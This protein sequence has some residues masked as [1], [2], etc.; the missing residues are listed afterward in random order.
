MSIEKITSKIISD[1][2]AQAEITLNEA[3]AQCDAILA[4]AA[5]KAEEIV[6]KAEIEGLAEKENLISRKKSVADI[7]GRKVILAEKQNLITECF[8]QALEK[9]VAMDEKQYVDFLAGLVKKSGV[10]E[11]ELIL[12]AADKERIGEALA[13]AVQAAM[14]DS[15]IVLSEE[16]RNVKGGFLLKTGAVYYN[17]TIEALVEEAREELTGEVALQLFQ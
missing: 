13:V 10:M 12:N 14:P 15:R 7:D 11:G 17:S 16:T 2:Q 3:K 4:E 6:K 8:A 9:I 1:A 5:V